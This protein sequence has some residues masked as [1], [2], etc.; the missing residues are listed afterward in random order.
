MLSRVTGAELAKGPQ[1]TCAEASAGRDQADRPTTRE[2]DANRGSRSPARPDQRRRAA[3]PEP[4]RAAARRG[5]PRRSPP[6]PGSAGTGAH[7]LRFALPK[8]RGRPSWAPHMVGP[9]HEPLAGDGLRPLAE[10]LS[11]R[12][13]PSEMRLALAGRAWTALDS[14]GSS[15][16]IS[17]CYARVFWVG[18]SRGSLLPGGGPRS[19]VLAET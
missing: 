9:A 18:T 5:R 3:E 7:Q 12:S 10:H 8:P 17:G 2:S 11:D 19:Y 4:S 15:V 13:H 1:G 6:R 14:T 16:R